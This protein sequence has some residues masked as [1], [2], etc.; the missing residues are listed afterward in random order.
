M[1]RTLREA[2]VQRYQSEL[3]CHL[4][5]LLDVYYYARR[6]KILDGRT[7]TRSSAAHEPQSLTDYPPT[8]IHQLPEP[9]I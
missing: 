6:L 8:R 4:A 1:N 7:P 3:R 2:T 9:N 5:L